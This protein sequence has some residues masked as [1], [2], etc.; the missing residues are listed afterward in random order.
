[1]K[2]SENL[3]FWLAFI[4]LL[5]TAI[6]S[7]TA[8]ALWYSLTFFVG[9]YLFIHWLGIIASVFIVVSN[10]FYYVLGKRISRSK[11]ILRIHVFGNLFAFLLVSLHFAQNV[12]RLAETPQRLAEGVALYFVLFIT[13]ATGFIV[14]FHSKKARVTK[15]IHKYALIVLLFIL[16]IHALEGFNL[17]PAAP[18]PSPSP[19]ISPTASPTPT[20]ASSSPSPSASPTPLPSQT[21]SPSPSGNITFWRSPRV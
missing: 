7:V 15:I 4:I 13:V 16:L 19:T 18:S 2:Y 8:F 9:P 17:L 20:P 1:L 6:F 11:T 14:R 3:E 12:G 5:A 21:P 10:P